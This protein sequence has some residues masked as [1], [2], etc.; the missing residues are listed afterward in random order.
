[1]HELAIEPLISPIGEYMA[2]SHSDFNL[3]EDIVVSVFK[4]LAKINW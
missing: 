3:L 1:M 2:K 4:P